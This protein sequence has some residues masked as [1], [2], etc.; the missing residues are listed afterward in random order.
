MYM[1]IILISQVL[2]RG[3]RLPHGGAGPRRGGGA[4]SGIITYTYMVIILYHIMYYII[5]HVSISARLRV[6]TAR[7][8]P[9]PGVVVSLRA[10]FAENRRDCN[11]SW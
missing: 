11:F 6:S 2:H 8:L 7:Q 1:Y 3:G 9:E 4:G 10:V 5:Y